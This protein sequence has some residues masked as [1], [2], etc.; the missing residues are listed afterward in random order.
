MKRSAHVFLRFA[1]VTA[2]LSS[3][4]FAAAQGAN[5][6]AAAQRVK[7]YGTYAFS[8]VGSTTDGLADGLCNFFTNQQIFNDVWF[9]FTAPES[10]VVE[11]STC[12]QTA[13]DSKIA[14]YGGTD[15]ASP[16]IAC[17]DD[18]C[19][20]Q[21]KVSFTATAGDS[22]LIRLGAYGATNFGSGTVTINPIALLH[23]VTDKSTGIRYIAVTG[24]TWTASQAMAVALGGNLASIND[25]AEQDFVHSNFGNIGGVD[26]RLW[27][28]FT[29][30]GAE[31]A[32]YWSDG[33]AAKYSNW[34]PG[35]PNNSSGVEHYAEMLGSNGKWND[36]NDA[37]AS[38]VHV[39]VIELP[40]GG[41]GTPCPADLDLD[42]S[43]GAADLATMLA[44]WGTDLADV[45][46]DGVTDAADISSL[47]SAWGACP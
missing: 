3:C 19:S 47:L 20:L 5:D 38:Y 17:S 10:F 32:F 13:L 18:N 21:T 36:L 29:D 1:A 2:A 42:G 7:G 40:G 33:S 34:N 11:V 43:V 23:D 4:A 35:E 25:Q 22:Y 37:G 27:I 31:G 6:C 41:G 15:C 39:A 9:T 45:T 12:A 44:Y 26:R 8:N 24:S 16:V 14:I 30:F 28:G 46:G